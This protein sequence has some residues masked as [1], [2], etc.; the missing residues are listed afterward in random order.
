MIKPM[1]VTVTTT[2]EVSEE[3][4]RALRH[5]TGQR[6]KATVTGKRSTRKQATA[7]IENFLE[8]ALGEVPFFMIAEDGDH[9]WSFWVCDDDTTSYVHADLSI[10]WYGTSYP[11]GYNP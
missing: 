5:R 2:F 9:S 6:G 7:A 8:H 3:G 4:L 1:T 10:E 11:E